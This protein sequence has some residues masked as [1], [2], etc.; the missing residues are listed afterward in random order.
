MR[1]IGRHRVCVAAQTFLCATRLFPCGSQRPSSRVGAARCVERHDLA[2]DYRRRPACHRGWRANVPHRYLDN[3]IAEVAVVRRRTVRRQP[4][5]E[6]AARMH[7]VVGYRVYCECLRPAEC[8]ALEY[9][10]DVL[11][12]D[13]P[14][15]EVAVRVECVNLGV[16]GFERELAVLGCASP[17][18]EVEGYRCLAVRQLLFQEQGDVF[19]INCRHRQA[20][21]RKCAGELADVVNARIGQVWLY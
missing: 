7:R 16:V 1:C 11:S 19:R 17:D 20:H 3:A 6:L 13:Y 8:S 10:V 2:R 21:L 18:V 4:N 9:P 5:R 15:R 14:S 12:G